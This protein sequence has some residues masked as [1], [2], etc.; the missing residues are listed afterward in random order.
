M[1]KDPSL[2]TTLASGQRVDIQYFE[3]Q[4]DNYAWQVVDYKECTGFLQEIKSEWALPLS[5]P[6]IYNRLAPV[7]LI[8][9]TSIY[10]PKNFLS[11]NIG[12]RTITL[13]AF[14]PGNVDKKSIPKDCDIRIQ[15]R[16]SLA[17]K[18][19]KKAEVEVEWPVRLRLKFGEQP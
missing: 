10:L 12:I 13:M 5:K 15:F 8:P 14:K 18:Y 6:R 7:Y 1:M 2:R 3:P 19:H 9:G 16:R 17:G 4:N 11:E